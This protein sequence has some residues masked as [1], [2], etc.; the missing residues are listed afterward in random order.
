MDRRSFLRGLLASTAAAPLATAVVPVIAAP[1]PSFD[2][3]T[4][5][6][7]WDAGAVAKD[8]SYIARIVNIDNS[9]RLI[10]VRKAA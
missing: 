10:A 4:S 2:Y 8:W 6:F 7:R 1:G 3:Y 9:P 5:H